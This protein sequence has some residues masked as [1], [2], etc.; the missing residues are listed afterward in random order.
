MSTTAKDL[1]VQILGDSSGADKMFAAF[2][3]NAGK[4]AVGVAAAFAGAKIGSLVSDNMDISAGQAKM[5]AQLGLTSADSARLGKLSGQVYSDNF[6]SSM[7]DVNSTL[8][9]V[10]QNIGDLRTTSDAELT[11]MA[12]KSSTLASTFD[13]D[14][15]GVTGA[16]G[17]ML[18]TGI[19]KNADEAFDILTKGLQNGANKAG[20]FLDTMTE[21]PVQFQALGLSA[22][23]ATGLMSQALAGGARSSD[24]AADALKEFS[25]R[26]I[27]GSTLSAQSYQALG[28]SAT[29]MTKRMSLGGQSAKDGLQLVLEKLRETED[30]VKRNAIAVGLFG[31]QAEDLKG[32]LG[33]MDVSTAVAG[34]GQVAGATQAMMD[35]M[36]AEPQSKIESMKRGFDTWQ[37]SLISTKGPVG[38]VAA[39]LMAFGPGAMQVIAAIGPMIAFAGAKVMATGATAAA[40]TVTEADTAATLANNVAW[41]ANPV[42]WI[43]IGIVA[44]IALLVGA[45]IL[46]VQNWGP[47]SEW[48]GNLWHSI[49]DGVTWFFGVLTE[50][51]LNFTPLGLIIKNWGAVTDWWNGWWGGILGTASN[52]IN[53]VGGKIDEFVGFFTSIPNRVGAAWTGLSNL[54]HGVMRNVA[55]YAAN[56]WNS[57]LGAINVDLPW[58]LGGAHIAFPKLQIP[59][60]AAGGVVSSPTIA[61]IGEAGPEAVVPLSQYN[62]GGSGGDYYV[63]VPVEVHLDGGVL[64]RTVE[65]VLLKRR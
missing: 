40:A 64:V 6:G 54:V 4:I 1:V 57:T 61:L 52:N 12:E 16:V 49:W 35:G 11:K 22:S 39:G 10:G 37:Q 26:A 29:D 45:A 23:D 56:T 25:I 59:A 15:N 46:I 42:A 33:K 50:G 48:F 53:W 47:I 30:P 51:F 14:M 55:V 38:D 41:Y 7:E 34:L 32:A 58:F 62:G 63:D 60:L 17:T 27:D 5:T 24:L 20:D 18:K 28:L 2:E 3:K 65:R 9:S 31:T 43:V 13:L 8:K 44:A 36:G 21:Y 19:A